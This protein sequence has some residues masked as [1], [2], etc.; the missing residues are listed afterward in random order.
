[1]DNASLKAPDS[2][3]E[4]HYMPDVSLLS[5]ALWAIVGYTPYTP[6]ARKTRQICSPEKAIAVRAEFARRNPGPGEKEEAL[7]Q[8]GAMPEFRLHKNTC[9]DIVH[10]VTWKNVK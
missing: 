10:F 7:R 5:R 1:M 6:P 8:I 9:R 3:H 4:S 2:R